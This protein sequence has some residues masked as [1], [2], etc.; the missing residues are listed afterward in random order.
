MK[1]EALERVKLL[2]P[3]VVAYN[4]ILWENLKRLVYV[5]Q[6][7]VADMIFKRFLS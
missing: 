6:F 5:V 3:H 2:Q 1:F 7:Q 4:R